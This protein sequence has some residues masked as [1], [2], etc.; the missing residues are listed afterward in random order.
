MAVNKFLEQKRR[1]YRNNGKLERFEWRFQ[2]L[3]IKKVKFGDDKML[4]AQNNT[5]F[6]GAIGHYTDLAT[7][8]LILA[9]LAILIV[10]IWRHKDTL[11]EIYKNKYET[12]EDQIDEITNEKTQLERQLES[13]SPENTQ[14]QTE[15]DFPLI[16]DLFNRKYESIIKGKVDLTLKDISSIWKGMFEDQSIRLV[17]I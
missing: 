12:A 1:N 16:A 10:A 14:Y 3:S 7:W 9:I 13:L 2:R 17:A 4:A 6:F 11:R 8:A 15:F 5:S